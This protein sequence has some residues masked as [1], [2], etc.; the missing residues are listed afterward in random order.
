MKLRD[1]RFLIFEGTAVI[2]IIIIGIVYFASGLDELLSASTYSVFFLPSH[3]LAGV[4]TW[5]VCRDDNWANLTVWQIV[6]TSIISLFIL[7]LQ[8]QGEFNFLHFLL[9]ISSNIFSMFIIPM[10]CLLYKIIINKRKPKDK[11][12][13]EK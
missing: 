4:A 13:S 1:R 10:Y 8:I 5:L 12:R 9:L 3:L 7:I 2:F 11:L 6:F